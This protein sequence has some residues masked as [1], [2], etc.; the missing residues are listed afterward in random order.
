LVSFQKG[1][2]QKKHINGWRLSFR[3]ENP[4][5][6]TS[7]SS[8]LEDQSAKRKTLYAMPVFSMRNVS[9]RVKVI[10]QYP[11]SPLTGEGVGE[12]EQTAPTSIL[13]PPCCKKGGYSGTPLHF[14]TKNMLKRFRIGC[15]NEPFEKLD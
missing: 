9:I 13:S 15:R 3:R 7:T 11:P 14:F 5:H 10:F 4:Y 12:G 8:D 1:W 6:C 2:M